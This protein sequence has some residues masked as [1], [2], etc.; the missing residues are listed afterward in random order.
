MRIVAP[1][2]FTGTVTG[3]GVGAALTLSTDDPDATA[4]A[5]A[6]LFAEPQVE[7]VA[8]GNGS[9][10]WQDSVQPHRVMFGHKMFGGS[11]DG[12]GTPDDEVVAV[13][14]L[15]SRRG[16]PDTEPF[17]VADHVES[18]TP[19]VGDIVAIDHL[20]FTAPSRDR[21][22]AVFGATLGFDFRLDRAIAPGTNQLFF[23][24]G[25][26]EHALVL[27]VIAADV[28]AGG[29]SAPCAL[30]GVAWRSVDL[31]ATHR[32]LLDA[33]V[34]VSELRVGAKPGTRIFTVRDRALATRTVVIACTSAKGDL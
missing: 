28:E 5:Y 25:G 14:R 3:V 2:Q 15:L 30:W 23:R 21:A 33:G 22:L 8:V 31:D 24:A 17:G 7:G 26:G 10:T 27:E 12:H 11:R 19:A 32:R 18:G 20:V 29:E 16:L 4:A 13:A 6:R 1:D 34:P 9:M